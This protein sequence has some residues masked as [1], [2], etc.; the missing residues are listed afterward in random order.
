MIINCQ[1]VVFSNKAYNAIIRES[2]DKDPVET[3]GILLGHILDNGIWIVMEVLP[4]GIHCIFERA[5]FEYDDAFVNYLAQS[6]ANQYK[7]PLDLL[8]LWHRHPASMDFFSSTDDETNAT[9]ARQNPKGVISGLVNI[10]PKFRLT[11]YHLDRSLGAIGYNR[12]NY[13]KVEVEVG[14]DIIPEEYFELRYYDGGDCELHPFV[15]SSGNR[16]NRSVCSV[17]NSRHSHS[18]PYQD[19]DV[20]DEMPLDIRTIANE[21]LNDADRQNPYSQST[22]TKLIDDIIE[23]LQALKKKWIAILLILIALIA[24]GYTI[25]LGYDTVKTGVE[26][27]ERFFHNDD[28]KTVC[29]DITIIRLNMKVGET[30]NLIK[31]MISNSQKK[32]ITWE[33]YDD[34]IVN[35]SERGVVSA[36]TKGETT[37]NAVINNSVVASFKID[38]TGNSLKQIKVKNDVINLIAGSSYKIET[39][40]DVEIEWKSRNPDIFSIEEGNIV[41]ALNAGEGTAEANV[42][43]QD[44]QCKIIVSSKESEQDYTVDINFKEE[45]WQLPVNMKGYSFVR[46]QYLS[47]LNLPNDIQWNSS[48][49]KI[50]TVDNDGKVT[51]LKEGFTEISISSSDKKISRFKLI[52]TKK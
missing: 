26:W 41:K 36:L 21:Q 4:P 43:G 32:K 35:V 24:C 23:V 25:K 5:Y 9:F 29:Q 6:V 28:K 16:L 47:I 14:D 2:F 12:P 44:L 49:T 17:D 37:I 8:G 33:S 48:D 7:N 50:A 45:E 11:M 31:K 27:V 40:S 19:F 1:M 3:G 22:R 39:S 18:Q 34:K 30:M 52:V 38:V 20:S 46:K 42:D 15:Q 13:E 10:D 51:T